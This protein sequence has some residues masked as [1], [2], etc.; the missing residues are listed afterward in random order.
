MLT[1][2]RGHGWTRV[3]TDPLIGSNAGAAPGLGEGR[4]RVMDAALTPPLRW[5]EATGDQDQG[6]PPAELAPERARPWQGALEAPFSLRSS[7]LVAPPCLL[8]GSHQHQLP[9][10]RSDLLT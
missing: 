3:A 9:R 5:D 6:K 2:E 8:P 7:A 4:G 10:A 1:C